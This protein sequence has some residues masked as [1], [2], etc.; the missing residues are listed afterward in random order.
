MA[1]DIVYLEVAVG[2]AELEELQ[3]EQR[4]FREQFGIDWPLQTIASIII[5]QA[6][7]EKKQKQHELHLKTAPERLQIVNSNKPQS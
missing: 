7:K 6:I 3:K 4:E 1:D 5:A 2:A